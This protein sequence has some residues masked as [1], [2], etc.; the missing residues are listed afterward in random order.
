MET[1]PKYRLD[2]PQPIPKRLL[3]LPVQNGMPVPWFCAEVDGKYDFRISD[4]RAFETAVQKKCCW[5]CGQP[6]GAYLSFP[7]GPM[8]AI[9][10]IISEPPSHT[11]CAKW[12]IAACPFLA[13]RQEVRREIDLPNLK[14]PA[15]IGLMRQPGVTCLWTTKS[16]KLWQVPNGVL[17]KLGDP[18]SVEWFRQGRPAT[19]AEVNEAIESGY[20]ELLKLAQVESASSVKALERRREALTPLLPP[21][22]LNV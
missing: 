16:Y 9:N 1:S 6:L 11:E 10:R 18:V 17:F 8:S 14:K 5:I 21:S 12:A 15:G 2:L 7:L 3:S 20:P 13:Q 4:S 19:R 22:P